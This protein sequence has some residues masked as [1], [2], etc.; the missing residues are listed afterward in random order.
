ME[1]EAAIKKAIKLVNP[2]SSEGDYPTDKERRL[3]FDLNA[4]LGE[5]T[6]QLEADK[7]SLKANSESWGIII[8]ACLAASK[9][10]NT[11]LKNALTY[12]SQRNSINATSEIMKNLANDL[13]R[14]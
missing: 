2:G 1:K 12:Y 14:E 7:V 5:Y 4:K 6:K 10:P 13:E 11:T 3:L 9:D 8:C